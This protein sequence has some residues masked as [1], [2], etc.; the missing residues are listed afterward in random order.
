MV[1]LV[2]EVKNRPAVEEL[3]LVANVHV[4]I[5]RESPVNSDK[6][7][8][9]IESSGGSF[10]LGRANRIEVHKNFVIGDDGPFRG[11]G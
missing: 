7:S 9:L 4:E 2:C 3:I 1:H 11:H 5:F 10:P 8:V 6:D